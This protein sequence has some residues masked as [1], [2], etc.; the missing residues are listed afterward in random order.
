MVA[1]GDNQAGGRGDHVDQALGPADIEAVVIVD[2]RRRRLLAAIDI[3]RLVGHL[4]GAGEPALAGRIDERAR[5]DPG[6][7]GGPEPERA[8]FVQAPV[9]V[10]RVRD[11]RA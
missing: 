8:S 11:S 4:R 2:L 10:G 3:R 1:D 6:R 5:L 7:S 9:V